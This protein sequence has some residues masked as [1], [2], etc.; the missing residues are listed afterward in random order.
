M[1]TSTPITS[2]V[3]DGEVCSVEAYA[4]AEGKGGTK[5]RLESLRRNGIVVNLPATY[6][7]GK[8]KAQKQFPY[9]AYL[10]VT[11]GYDLGDTFRIVDR[12]V[13]AQTDSLSACLKGSIKEQQDAIQ[14]AE[15][16]W[17]ENKEESKPSAHIKSLETAI[18]NVVADVKAGKVSQETLDNILSSVFATA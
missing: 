16:V 2:V 4:A 14:I 7:V 10:Y 12:L 3:L 5:G 1:E 18:K 8:E 15:D 17:V 6:K 9:K 11:L 13:G